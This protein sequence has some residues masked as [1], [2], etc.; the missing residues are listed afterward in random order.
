MVY[1]CVQAGLETCCTEAAGN[2]VVPRLRTGNESR[3]GI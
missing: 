2:V 3:E 1:T